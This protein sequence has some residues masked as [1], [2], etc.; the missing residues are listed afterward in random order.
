M[1]I[2][3]RKKLLVIVDRTTTSDMLSH[4]CLDHVCLPFPSFNVV[5]KLKRAPKDFAFLALSNIAQGGG[6]GGGRTIYG[7]GCSSGPSC[8]KAN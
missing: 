1:N 4:F 8:L 2:I 6:G 3:D 5:K 7:I